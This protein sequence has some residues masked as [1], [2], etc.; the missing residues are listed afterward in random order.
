MNKINSTLFI[1][2]TLTLVACGNGGSGAGQQAPIVVNPLQNDAGISSLTYEFKR[3]GCSTG[4]Q[5]FQNKKE[6]CDG[7]LDD[8]RNNNCAREMRLEHY[9]RACTGGT[10]SLGVLPPM[11]TVRCSA[12]GM[13]LKDRTFVDNMNPFNPQRRQIITERFWGGRSA[14]TYDLMGTL[15]SNYGK[16]QIVLRPAQGAQAAQSEITIG[17]NKNQDLF[18]AR[19]A[20]GGQIQLTVTNFDTEREMDVVCQTDKAFRKVNKDLST[21]RCTFT[22]GTGSNPVTKE[23]NLQWDQ[24]NTLEREV[25]RNRASEALIVRLIPAHQGGEAKIELEAI[26]LD[27]NK[28]I[29]AESGLNEGLS[30]GY[31]SQQSGTLMNFSCAPASK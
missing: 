5:R 8:V 12:N 20:M 28:T 6:Y 30:I 26:E 16:S 24:R 14:V 27:I 4:V 3:N 17:Q 22:L 18:S 19:T 13:D 1:L 2:V 25:Y 9:N 10:S 29:R 11:S 21:V 7:L 23:Q 31:R 15:V